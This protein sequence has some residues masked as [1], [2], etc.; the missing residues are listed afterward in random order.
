MI[1]LVE[2]LTGITRLE[3]ALMRLDGALKESSLDFVVSLEPAVRDRA[4]ELGWDV[5][6]ATYAGHRGFERRSN[7]LRKLVRV[8]DRLLL[9]HRI[10][11]FSTRHFVAL[12]LVYRSIQTQLMSEAT[13]TL[14][15]Y[16]QAIRDCLKDADANVSVA[17]YG[18][19]SLL[20]IANLG[21]DPERV[22]IL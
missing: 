20:T 19:L 11:K 18:T 9:N 12:H 17:V 10:S 1:A 8:K 22:H 15:R 21:F 6:P 5:Y 7:A 16:D 13:T 2:S 14:D 4:Y 3:H